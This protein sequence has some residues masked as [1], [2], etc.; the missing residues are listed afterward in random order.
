MAVILRNRYNSIYLIFHIW[1][2]R[3]PP[4][5][6]FM[7]KRRQSQWVDNMRYKNCTP[8]KNREK[9]PHSIS[10]PHHF[11][12]R[13]RVTTTHY[14]LSPDHKYF[15]KQTQHVSLNL[16][17]NDTNTPSNS[18]AGNIR[19]ECIIGNTNH[20]GAQLHIDGIAK[21]TEGSIWDSATFSG[22]KDWHL[23]KN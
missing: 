12:Q 17:H 6:P 13:K 7:V 23:S 2:W 1:W 9:D 21:I 10:C 18:D 15:N 11:W 5:F 14:L 3:F 4:S 22:R 16:V 8:N 19:F 20:Q